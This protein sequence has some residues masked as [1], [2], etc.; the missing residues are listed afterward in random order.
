MLSWQSNKCVEVVKNGIHT[1]QDK[2]TKGISGMY[3]VSVDF[4]YVNLQ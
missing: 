4:K 2:L 1:I 3:N